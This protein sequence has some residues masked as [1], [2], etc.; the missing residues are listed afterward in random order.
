MSNDIKKFMRL[1]ESVETVSEGRADDLLKQSITS[2]E[3]KYNESDYDTSVIVKTTNTIWKKMKSSP[4][5]KHFPNTW[6]IYLAE[7]VKS[8]MFEVLMDEV[9]DSSVGKKIKH[10]SV[11]AQSVF[12]YFEHLT[13][14]SYHKIQNF[15]PLESKSPISELESLEE[16]YIEISNE[17]YITPT[18][19]ETVLKSFGDIAWFDL[20]KGAC[21]DEA[22]A[23]G[24]C[25]NAPSES[26]GD[27]IFSLRKIIKIDGEELHKPHLTFIF[28]DG[29]LGEM[30]GRA[31]EKPAERYHKYI[32]ELLKLPIITGVIGGGYEPM[33]NFEIEDLNSAQISELRELKGDDFVDDAGNTLLPIKA[34][35]DRL[36]GGDRSVIERLESKANDYIEDEIMGYNSSDYEINS[37]HD[38]HFSVYNPGFDHWEINILRTGEIFNLDFNGVHNYKNFVEDHFVGNLTKSIH[39]YILSVYRQDIQDHYELDEDEVDLEF[40]DDEFDQILDDIADDVRVVL[41]RLNSDAYESGTSSAISDNVM[42]SIRDFLSDLSFEDMSLFEFIDGQDF[43]VKDNNVYEYLKELSTLDEGSIDDLFKIDTPYDGYEEFDH[44]LFDD[45][46]IIKDAFYMENIDLDY[47]K[48]EE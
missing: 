11:K 32:M 21:D 34:L 27:K 13:G 44:K 36:I 7:V 14:I 26:S 2:I 45:E 3:T 20:G 18:G 4:S 47:F 5:F 1:L 42:S 6:K 38:S 43:K 48:K 33:N 19:D 12:N 37:V 22:D 31:N 46:A 30:K 8:N 10:P 28:N 24:H 9:N 23:M 35:S 16:E 29:Y 17:N 41:E 40:I 15:N 25:G 39:R